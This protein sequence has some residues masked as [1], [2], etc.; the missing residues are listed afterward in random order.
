MKKRCL[1]PNEPRYKDYGARGIK[2]C[3]IWLI[4]FDEFAEWA[5]NNGYEPGLTI[6]RKDVN[7]DYCPKNCEWISRLRQSYNKRTTVFVTYKGKTKCLTDWCNEL[8][9]K[10]DTMHHRIT[11]GMSPEETFETPVLSNENSFAGICRDH[12]MN[13]SIVYDRIHK[14]GWTLEKALNTPSKGL[15]ANQQSYSVKEERE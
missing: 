13:S 1:N 7:G 4:G 12:E 15:G 14:L 2:I 3:S 11:H 8:N 6:E 5:L 9:L 10:Y